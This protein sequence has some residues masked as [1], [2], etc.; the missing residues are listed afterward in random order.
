MDFS[1]FLYD[2]ILFISIKGV[3]LGLEAEWSLVR[4][5]DDYGLLGI[6]QCVLDISELTHANSKGLNVLIKMLTNLDER[7][8]DMIIMHPSPQVQKLFNITK[9][10]MIFKIASSRYEAMTILQENQQR[11]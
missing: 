11:Q 4:L 10:D 2:R 3:L 5:L 8:G 6:N 1:F 7:Q 9:L